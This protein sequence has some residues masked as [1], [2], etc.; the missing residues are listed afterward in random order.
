MFHQPAGRLVPSTI[1][2]STSLC[3]SFFFFSEY[4][5]CVHVFFY[6]NSAERDCFVFVACPC[7]QQFSSI[8]GLW[9]ERLVSCSG[10]LPNGALVPG[11]FPGNP[12][13]LLTSRA[14][15]ILLKFYSI[16]VWNSRCNS[17]MYVTNEVGK[18]RPY[19]LGSEKFHV[20]FHVNLSSGFL[21]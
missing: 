16:C 19:I 5:M 13:D 8:P 17:V 21:L 3:A 11:W 6:C 18:T 10:V 20:F 9:E 4:F 12:R 1:L 14:K 15:S 7:A 2:E